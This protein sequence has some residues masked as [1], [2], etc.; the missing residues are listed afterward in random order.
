MQFGSHGFIQLTD[1]FIQLAGAVPRLEIVPTYRDSLDDVVFR[2]RL[3]D[4]GQC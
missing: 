1:N 3:S 2:H 4:P